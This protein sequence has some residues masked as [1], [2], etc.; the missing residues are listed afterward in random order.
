MLSDRDREGKELFPALEAGLSA[1]EEITEEA[2]SM[3]RTPRRPPKLPGSTAAEE[4]RAERERKLLI[5][6][7]LV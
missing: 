1:E 3:I 6:V 7:V 2:G 4:G 5:P